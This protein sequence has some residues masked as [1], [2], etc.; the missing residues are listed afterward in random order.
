MNALAHCQL[1]GRWRC[2]IWSPVSRLRLVPS[3]VDDTG[4]RRSFRERR[5]DLT[6]I[7]ITNDDPIAFGRR[8]PA[9]RIKAKALER[10]AIAFVFVY[11]N[12]SSSKPIKHFMNRPLASLPE[13]TRLAF[14]T[15]AVFLRYF[16]VR[17]CS[18]PFP[19]DDLCRSEVM[20]FEP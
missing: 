12:R 11:R 9:R 3:C 20:G 17:A 18:Q 2:S 13:P 10:G 8:L 5:R 16:L 4:D 1:I 6:V 15:A 7:A 19:L 14:S